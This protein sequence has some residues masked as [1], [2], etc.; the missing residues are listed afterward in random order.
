MTLWLAKIEQDT[1]HL[2]L[3]LSASQGSVGN[4]LSPSQC[5]GKAYVHITFPQSHLKD[6]TEFII[7][8]IIVSRCN[9]K[10]TIR[11]LFCQVRIHRSN[12][13]TNKPNVHTTLKNKFIDQFLYI[14]DF[15]VCFLPSCSKPK[16]FLVKTLNIW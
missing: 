11:I 3:C 5:R 12:K 1:I 10:L 4:N 9:P 8:V 2:H 7:I 16:T 15:E 6:Y 14:N 13:V